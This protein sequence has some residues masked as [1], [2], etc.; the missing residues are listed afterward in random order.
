MSKYSMRWRLNF[1]GFT[2]TGSW[3]TCTCTEL[4]TA[5]RWLQRRWSGV[6]FFLNF[7]VKDGFTRSCIFFVRHR[8]R[9]P[10]LLGL[11]PILA[12][13][14]NMFDHSFY[15]KKYIIIIY[16]IIISFIIKDTLNIIYI[17]LYFHNFFE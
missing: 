8:T 16:F 14:S 11:D 1:R 2:Q 5:H 6:R 12:S 7:L 10:C 15:L 4:W 3:S 9:R 17:F 13:C